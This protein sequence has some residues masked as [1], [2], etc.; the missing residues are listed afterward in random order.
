M[1]YRGFETESSSK[2]IISWWKGL[3]IFLLLIPILSFFSFVETIYADK[4]KVLSLFQF[5]NYYKNF[6]PYQLGNLVANYKSHKN[7]KDNIA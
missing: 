7:L 1:K 4:Q 3:V 5:N 2:K 6:I